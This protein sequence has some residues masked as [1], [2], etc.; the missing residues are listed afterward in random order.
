[1]IIVCVCV[2]VQV[3]WVPL[4]KKADF[5]VLSACSGGKVLLWRLD[6]DQHALVLT[7]A[8]SLEPRHIPQSL[9][10]IQSEVLKPLL[11]P[12]SCCVWMRWQARGCSSVGITSLAVS[13]WDSDTFLVGSEGGLL[14]RCSFS[15]ALSTAPSDGHSRT[16]R[17]PVV[18]SFRRGSGPVHSI[19]SSP[20]HWSELCPRPDARQRLCDARRSC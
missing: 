7:A 20:F 9:K 18:F 10:V 4:Q 15:K 2:C 11:P 6:A 19:H 1:M 12:L 5:G 3:V 8:F 13:S 16:H 17:A 14:L